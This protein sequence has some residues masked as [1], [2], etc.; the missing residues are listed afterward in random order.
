LY[1]NP[2]IEL[3]SDAMSYCYWQHA[4]QL[5]QLGPLGMLSVF[6]VAAWLNGRERMQGM[7]WTVYIIKNQC[8]SNELHFYSP[9]W[10]DGD[11][12]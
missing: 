6:L 5:N 8:R 3:W 12:N 2:I 11:K 10:N 9:C 1:C 4:V 7:L